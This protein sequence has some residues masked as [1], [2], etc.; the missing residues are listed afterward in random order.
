MK[1][2]PRT[3]TLFIPSELVPRGPGVG[4]P[5]ID[6]LVECVVLENSMHE[7]LSLIEL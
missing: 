4:G 2:L 5:K 7:T 1:A 6:T 3:D